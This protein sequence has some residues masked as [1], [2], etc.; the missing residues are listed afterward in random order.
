MSERCKRRTL[1]AVTITTWL[2]AAGLLVGELETETLYLRS[3]VLFA[4]AL[5]SSLTTASLMAMYIGPLEHVYRAGVSAG[6][7]AQD[8]PLRL[9]SNAA[10]PITHVR[11]RTRSDN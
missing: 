3:L 6:R 8:P 4:L 9:V 5:A 1:H 11:E 2:V 7:A 10:I